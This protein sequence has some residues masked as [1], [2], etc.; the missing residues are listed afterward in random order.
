MAHIYSKRSLIGAKPTNGDQ[1][2]STTSTTTQQSSS[3]D[4]DYSPNSVVY[5][6]MENLLVRMQ[7]EHTGVQVRT[8]KSFISKIPSVF[9][10]AD[11]ITWIVKNLDTDDTAEALHLANLLSAHGYIFPIDDHIL[12]VRNDNTFYRFQTPCFW[13]SM[14]VEPENTDYA[15]YLCKRTMQN[16][17]RLELA[18]YEAENLARLQK[19]FARKWEFVFMQAEA[20]AKVDKKRD[21]LDRQILDSQERAFWDVH[22][23]APNYS[24]FGGCISPCIVETDQTTVSLDNLRVEISQLTKLLDRRRIKVSKVAESYISYFEQYSEYDAFITPPE[25]FNPWLSDTTEFWE[26]ETTLKDIPQRRVKRWSFSIQ[27]LVRDTAGREHFRHFL[28]KEFSAENL[29][30]WE[31]CQQLKQVPQKDVENTVKSI[32][33]EYLAPGAIDPVNVD[34]RVADIVRRSMLEK[35]DRY[36]LDEAEDHIFKLMKNDSYSRYI[37]SD[38]YKEFLSGSKKKSKKRFTS[39]V[40]RFKDLTAGANKTPAAPQ[41]SNEA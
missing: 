2:T 22:R 12:T 4:D 39:E 19:T 38:M 36:C 23:P 37:R 10:G 3:K 6:K 35:L 40:R 33:S 30:F 15:V 8:V 17:Q 16:K 20:Q 28:E 27:E 25:C 41:N 9:T 26:Q 34:S 32:Y 29:K 14:C 11:L 18:D 5:K 1:S 21:K 13:P 7:A 31:A 24:V